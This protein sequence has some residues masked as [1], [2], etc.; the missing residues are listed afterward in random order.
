[1]AD[2]I[3]F[4]H[5][6]NS[7]TYPCDVEPPCEG[8]GKSEKWNGKSEEWPLEEVVSQLPDSSSR[9]IRLSEGSK[10][11]AHASS[12]I[13][14]E[15]NEQHGP[16]RQQFKSCAEAWTWWLGVQ[17]TPHDVAMMNALQKMSRIKCGNHNRDNYVDLAGYGSAIAGEF[18]G[19]AFKK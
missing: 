16:R 18:A 8:D 1:M 7:N 9:E 11:L 10:I 19:D 5:G 13:D 4:P 14:G 3:G 15:R 12:L 6:H 2:I 17:V